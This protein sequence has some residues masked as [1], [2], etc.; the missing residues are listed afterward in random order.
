MKWQQNDWL[1]IVEYNCNG[2]KEG[3][4]EMII[5]I[6]WARNIIDKYFKQRM[7]KI[8]RIRDVKKLEKFNKIWETE[9]ECIFCST[10][11]IIN[12]YCHQNESLSK[13]DKNKKN[14]AMI[15]LGCIWL[16]Y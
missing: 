8:E 14:Y 5:W 6:D 12:R 3:E 15:F 11:W 7:K 2:K 10:M 4:R 9:G 13:K 1:V 16:H